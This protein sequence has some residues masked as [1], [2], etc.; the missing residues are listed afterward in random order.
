RQP[1]QQQL[2]EALLPLLRPGGLLV[3]A[4]CTVHPVEN[5]E[6]IAALLSRHPQ[7]VLRFSQQWWPG[8]GSGDGFYAAVLAT[9]AG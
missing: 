2:L 4:T 1:L 8:P 7:L 5:G 6:L 3:Y 9:T